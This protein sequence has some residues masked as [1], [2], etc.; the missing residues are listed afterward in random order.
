MKFNW[1]PISQCAPAWRLC[2]SDVPGKFCNLQARLT[3]RYV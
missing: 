1:I 2:L 3:Y